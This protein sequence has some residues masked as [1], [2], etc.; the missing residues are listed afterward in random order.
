MVERSSSVERLTRFGSGGTAAGTA[1]VTNQFAALYIE[2]IAR[3][4]RPFM[5][6]ALAQG[7]ALVPGVGAFEGDHISHAA[8]LNE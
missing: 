7:L 8:L 1:V 5:E 6:A 3:G 4:Y 2:G